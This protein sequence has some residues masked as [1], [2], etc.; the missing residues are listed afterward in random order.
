M[1]SSVEEAK[2]RQMGPGNPSASSEFLELELQSKLCPCMVPKSLRQM[3]CLSIN[4]LKV[5]N[6]M[7][8]D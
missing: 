5:G 3:A 8:H 4:A 1:G 6:Q 2:P 7:K